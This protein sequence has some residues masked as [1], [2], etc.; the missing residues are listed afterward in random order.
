MTDTK[1][2][3]PIGPDDQASDLAHDLTDDLTND[4]VDDLPVHHS[5]ALRAEAR[6]MIAMNEPDLERTQR[7]MTG[8]VVRHKGGKLSEEDYQYALERIADGTTVAEVSRELGVNRAAFNLKAHYD[9][10]FAEAFAE[11]KRIAASSIVEK[12]ILTSQGIE[13]Y[14]TGSIERDKLV[15]ST[16]RWYASKTDPSIF[17]DKVQ[18]DHRQ[19]VISIDGEE[20]TK[21]C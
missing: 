20:A 10:E 3:P 15:A 8:P 13:G 9:K 16:M 18:L 21:W 1:H 11:A 19:I 14:T 7:I 5:T 12:M 17:G 2:T 6:A 4:Q